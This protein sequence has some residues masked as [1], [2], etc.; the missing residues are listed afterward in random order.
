[1]TCTLTRVFSRLHLRQV[2]NVCRE[3]DAFQSVEIFQRRQ[4]QIL[5]RHI[6]EFPA[7]REILEMRKNIFALNISIR[8]PIVAVQQQGNTQLNTVNRSKKNGDYTRSLDT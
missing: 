2:E 5:K 3:G 1:M 4:I 6:L 7:T 8:T